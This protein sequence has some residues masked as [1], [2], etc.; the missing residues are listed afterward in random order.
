MSQAKSEEIDRNLDRLSEILHELI[1][2][3]RGEY[4]LM[5]HGEVVDFFPD[6]LEAQIAGNLRFA[7]YIFSIQCVQESPEQLGYFSYAID[8]GKA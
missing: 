2:N 3:H 5:R 8:S 7:D 6:P 4:A 1:P